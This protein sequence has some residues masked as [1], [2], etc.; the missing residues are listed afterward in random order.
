MPKNSDCPRCG[1]KLTSDAPRGLCPVCLFE[2][3]L[4]HAA[5]GSIIESP[6]SAERSEPRTKSPVS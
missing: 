6:E 4:E 3:A 2:I 5:P 1:R